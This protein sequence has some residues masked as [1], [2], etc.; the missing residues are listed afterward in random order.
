MERNL[1]TETKQVG[2]DGGKRKD[3]NL[4]CFFPSSKDI[5]YA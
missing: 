4:A 3:R 5:Y 2:Q 1:R